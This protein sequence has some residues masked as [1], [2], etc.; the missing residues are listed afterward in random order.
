MSRFPLQQ[1]FILAAGLGQRLAPLTEV[2][3]KPLLPLANRPLLGLL[4]DHLTGLGL[5]RIGINVHHLAG[6]LIDY[7]AGLS[8][9]PEMVV[10]REETLKGTGGGLGQAAKEFGSGP[11]L[12]VNSDVVFDFDLGRVV[13]AHLASGAAVSLVLHD[14]PGLNQVIVEG[15]RVVG[16]RE[17]QPSR[18]VVSQRRL[19]YACVQVVSPIVFDYLPTGGYADLIEAYQRMI[20]H[21]LTIRAHF[22]PDGHFW[23][24]I[25]CLADYLA[26]HREVLAGGRSIWGR[27]AQG[28]VLL[29][30][31]AKLAAGA[32]VRGF[33]CLGPGAKVEAGARLEE[34]VILEGARVKTGAEVIRSVLG[35]RAEVGN[36]VVDA[37][38]VG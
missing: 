35:P 2:V 16:F 24:D 27:R 26:L 21:G 13:T 4:L 8:D 32:Q 14:R 11:L 30:Q 29:G 36:R 17:D 12:V 1:A 6:R 20:A 7:L 15:E 5:E 33:A 25:G 22:L 10:F 28:P 19:A 31:G 3:P 9:G 23:T 38:R 18:G 37:V 34:A